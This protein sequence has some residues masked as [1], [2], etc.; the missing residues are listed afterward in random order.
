MCA[1]VIPVMHVHILVAVSTSVSR[2]V[3]VLGL[4]P[5]TELQKKCNAM[6]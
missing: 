5:A 6:H 2:L 1:A 3:S 4:K